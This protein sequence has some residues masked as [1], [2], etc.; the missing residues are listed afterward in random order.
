MIKAF[1][2]FIFSPSA[3]R[4]RKV[5]VFAGLGLVLH[6]LGHAVFPLRGAGNLANSAPAEVI[7]D[8]AW[9]LAM[10]AFAAGGFGLLGWYPFSKV[11]RRA[12]P[13]AVAASAVI[14]GAFHQLDLLPGALIDVLVLVAF[15]RSTSDGFG[16][17][18]EPVASRWAR[19]AGSVVAVSVVGYLTLCATTRSSHRRWG[20]TDAELH[21]TLPGDSPDRDPAFEVNHAITID[22]PPSS[23]W[24]WLVQI[25]Q[26]RGGFYSYDWLENLFGLNIH[27]ADRVHP[28]WQDRSEG[29]LVR[30]APVDWLG[31]AL[32][33]DVGW[34]VTHVESERV[35]VLRWWGAFVLLPLSGDK[36]RMFVR[37]KV[38]DPKIPVW[39]A[40]ISFATF[41]LPHF[42]MERRMLIGIKQRVEHQTPEGP[43]LAPEQ[44]LA[45]P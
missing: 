26:D 20:T 16:A 15:Y 27:N 42:I 8:L 28:E 37:S 3:L 41:E 36:T 35:M 5:R 22:A 39:G 31:G 11:W 10:V 32:G 40:A 2:A 21:A 18:P 14:L 9:G 29:D 38:S 33:E 13:V 6:G 44:K 12:V 1:T 30:A 24:P 4:S 23:V 19:A 25:G 17:A 43:A 45:I 34:R 7:V